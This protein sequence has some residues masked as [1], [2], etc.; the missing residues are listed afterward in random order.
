MTTVF[1]Q[2]TAVA[3]G[4]LTGDYLWSNVANWTNGVPVDGEGVVT[5]LIGDDDIAALSLTSLTLDGGGVV[6]V[7]GSSLSVTTV[8]VSGSDGLLADA[9]AAGGPVNVTVGSVT[10][11]NGSFAAYGVGGVFVD[12]SATDLGENYVAGRGGLLELAATPSSNSVLQYDGTGTFA[13]GNPGA[14]NAFALSNVRSGDVL[15]LPGSSASSVSFGPTSL[16]VTTSDGTYAFSNVGYA[17]KTL[18]S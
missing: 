17:N 7:I 9:T 15:E 2:V 3:S 18:N 5:A 1:K 11:T 14:S 8:A 4:P 16:S 12:Q 13:L 6:Y 10:G